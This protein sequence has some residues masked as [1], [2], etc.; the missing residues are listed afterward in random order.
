M[1]APQQLDGLGPTNVVP[2]V[3]Q[4]IDQSRLAIDVREGFVLS[5][6]DG[7]TTLG[8][9]CMLSPFEVGDTT[10]ILIRLWELGAIDLPGR[11]RPV[12]ASGA[13]WSAVSESRDR[14]PN[15]ATPGSTTADSSAPPDP[16]PLAEL[17]PL[18][19][20]LDLTVAQ[21]ERIDDVF[22]RLGQRDA[23]EILEVDRTADKKTIKR[24][25]FRLSKEFHP[26][27][28]FG[29][30]LGDNALRLSAIFQEIKAAFELLSNE[31]RRATYDRPG[32]DS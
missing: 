27:R 15:P 20:G 5:R 17:S 31:G 4:G 12:G 16:R 11:N 30:R 8:E 9:I 29:R 19:E 25:Y 1:G 7:R 18:V 22:A 14:E 21:V 2:S 23:Y 24:A 26:D 10:R 6:V 13:V 3:S 28:F 32:E